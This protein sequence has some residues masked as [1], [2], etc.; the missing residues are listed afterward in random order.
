MTGRGG[1]ATGVGM[2]M[3]YGRVILEPLKILC[4]VWFALVI[5]WQ[6][7]LMFAVL[8]PV[9]LV[10]L[11]YVTKKMK[12]AA[13]RVL[14][15]MSDIVRTLKDVLDGI[16]V[17]KAFTQEAHERRRFRRAEISTPSNT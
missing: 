16:R 1:S 5:S 12:R 8:V 3:L 11:T 17:V 6:L 4:C 13:K 7:T 15:R 9:A 10:T 2:K 14:E